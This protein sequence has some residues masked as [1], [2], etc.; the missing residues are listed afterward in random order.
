MILMRMLLLICM[1]SEPAVFLLFVLE[2][3][4]HTPMELS[5]TPTNL[6]FKNIVSISIYNII[7]SICA[8]IIMIF[9]FESI[10]SQSDPRLSRGYP[11]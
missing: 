11:R 4:F 6:H 7:S 9:K 8:D 1:F 5:T 3:V 2:T 10:D